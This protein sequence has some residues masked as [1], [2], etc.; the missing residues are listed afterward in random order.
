MLAR[1]APCGKR[2]CALA[3]PNHACA[4]ARGAAPP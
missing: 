3:T 2:A 4:L 1:R